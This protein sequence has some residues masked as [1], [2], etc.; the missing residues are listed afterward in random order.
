MPSNYARM[1]F[2]EKQSD[3]IV[4]LIASEQERT[5]FKKYNG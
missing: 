1:V 2:D 4:E 5:Y 3:T